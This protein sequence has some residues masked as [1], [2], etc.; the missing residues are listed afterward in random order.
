[1]PFSCGCRARGGEELKGLALVQGQW[2][3]QYI[4]EAVKIKKEEEKGSDKKEA[5]NAHARRW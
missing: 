1:M 3:P 2:P 4:D 5:K